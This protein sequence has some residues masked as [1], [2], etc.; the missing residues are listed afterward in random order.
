[1]RGPHWGKRANC[2]SGHRRRSLL[3]MV[4]ALAALA[5]GGVLSATAEAQPTCDTFTDA[6]GTD[7]ATLAN[8]ST[9]ALPGSDAACWAS[10]TTVTVAE[11]GDTADSLEGSGDLD[12]TAGSLTLT[13]ASDPSTVDNL[14]LDGGGELDGADESL[15][16]SGTFTWGG[17]VAGA[18][19]LNNTTT[20]PGADL[21]IAA[22]TVTMDNTSMPT[23]DGG[24]VSVGSAVTLGSGLTVSTGT[25]FS[26]TGTI[27]AGATVAGTG[28]TFT[29]AGVS[30]T[31]SYGF[32]SNALVLTGGT[33]TVAATDALSCGSLTISGGALDASGTVDDT[34]ALTLSNGTLDA[35][36]SGIVDSGALTVSGGTLDAVSGSIV[37]PSSTTIS[38]GE[39]E[40]AGTLQGTSTA[41]EGGILQDTGSVTG[42]VTL[43]SGT[44]DGTGTVTGLVTNT[45]G[46]VSPG[47]APGGLTVGSYTQGTGGTL[48]IAINSS[49][50][51]SQL[52]VTGAASLAGDL[53]LTGSPT[54]TSGN[55]F[56]VLTYASESGTLTLEGS[57]FGSY[58]PSYGATGLTLTYFVPPGNCPS[59]SD[60][61]IPAGGA[62]TGEWNKTG[63]GGGT[64]LP[65]TPTSTSI[66]CWSTADTVTMG[67]GDVQTV[68]E[69]QGGA[70]DIDGGGL[71]LNTADPSALSGT[72]S[73][74]NPA[75]SLTAGGTL[76]GDGQALTLTGGDF[77]WGA[78]SGTATQL[79][80][81][82]ITQ[83]GGSLVVGAEA[84]TWA[85]GSINTPS[86]SI[87]A[88]TLTE[89][90][91]PT[92]TTT[93]GVT[94]AGTSVPASAAP[95]TITAAGVTNTGTT[96]LLGSALHVE[97][98]TNSIA[99]ALTT[100]SLTTDTGTT[101]TLTSPTALTAYA[102]AISGAIT[103]TGTFTSGV[104]SGTGTTTIETGTP[105]SG[106]VSTAALDVVGGSLTVDNAAS[107]S[108]TTLHETAG[109]V[110][111]SSGAS[112]SSPTV[113]VAAG[114]LTVDAGAT[115]AAATGT[116]I[117]TGTLNLADTTS[118]TGALSLTG[119]GEL[120][121]AAG[122]ALTDAG[123]FTWSAGT[124]N[125]PATDAL[126]ITTGAGD[127]ISGAVTLD[128]GSITTASP[129]TVTNANVAGTAGTFSVGGVLAGTGTT[130]PYGFGTHALT[131][132]GGTTT[133]ARGDTLASGALTITG[134]TV[135]DDG[136]VGT[137]STT[138]TGGTLDGTGTVDGTLTNSSGTVSP[139][140]TVPG[141]GTLTTTGNYS[142]GGGAE[143]AI[144]LVGTTAGSGFSQLQVAGY[145]SLG[146]NLY[147]ADG[148]GFVPAQRDTFAIVTA[149]QTPTGALT[150]TG[151]GAGS[152]SYGFSSDTV[153]LSVLPTPGNAGPPAI[154]GTLSVGQ[155]LTCSPGTW[156]G[157]EPITFAYQWNRD[158]SPIANATSQTY[159]VTSADQSHSLTCTVT[160]TN[161]QGPGPPATSP[162]VSVAAP[163]PPPGAPVN[164][165]APA[166]SGTPTPGNKLSCS[167][168]TW[169]GTPTA[170]TYQWYRN[171]SPISGATLSTY[172]VQIADEGS[173]LTCTVTA[174]NN[175]GAG[176]PQTTV[177]T[178]VAEPGTLSCPKPSG[179]L[180]GSSL[181]PL[182]LG[183]TRAHAR[184]TLKRYTASGS[185]QDNFCLY[186]G[187]GIVAGYPSTKLLRSLSRKERARVSGKIVLALTTNLYYSLDG[188]RPGTK[189]TTA[190]AKRLRLG[191]VF[192]IGLNDWYIAPG[193]AGDDVLRVRG[194]II[195]EIGIANR[196]LLQGRPAQQR[197]LASFSSA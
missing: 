59:G 150:V 95:G 87:G 172:T 20:L 47:N 53:N 163:P 63:T 154:T 30:G 152:Y 96:S 24:S 81:L 158:G 13:S 118:T 18:A 156:S 92:L 177:A 148:S 180:S 183:A 17:S 79:T 74:P 129:V 169:S 147:L 157:N 19:T 141:L 128:G 50:S 121:G 66:A 133:V 84:A 123:A 38:G 104:L 54:L 106:S 14:T 97:A 82:D 165:A 159:V 42:A 57:N 168:G 145:V 78:A 149:T 44:L 155:T 85:G 122:T 109:T 140:N 33:T 103:G 73:P 69:V 108:A 35:E 29:A 188:A 126:A 91:A 8:W 64:W 195:Q 100:E 127:A 71:T 189:L 194:G 119:A 83:T 197:F 2:L 190:L 137:T 7:W 94:F 27:T 52:A 116:T 176:T 46:T 16:V 11:A 3:V 124:I 65:S 34:G 86:A 184:H 62:T 192:H 139:G 89:T 166:V 191:K 170:Y 61:F 138:M 162:A 143:L 51:F 117:G 161:S 49:T 75:L 45:S 55:S 164:T 77:D 32:G 130:G 186:G 60:V 37:D 105:T 67:S 179:R 175:V 132:T 136:I 68:E 142:Q 144:E 120:N 151:P 173:S 70:L 134:G 23:I 48:S 93:G 40:D 15:T 88:T 131:L 187:W 28:A 181:G 146:G 112:L 4:V 99:G 9:G 174:T 36:S 6:S 171:G 193:A 10:G 5:L 114:T 26:S 107:I 178:V 90:L 41:V 22:P 115:Y 80:D 31:G 185:G 167:T 196:A 153:T 76:S 135:Q 110:T 21:A 58:I 113:D 111:V 25:A 12:I 1:M 43:T 101:L 98:G 125:S 56:E 72:S 102:G 39:L 160:A 182:A